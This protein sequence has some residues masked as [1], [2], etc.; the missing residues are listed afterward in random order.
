MRANVEERF[1][2][3]D[4]LQNPDAGFSDQAEELKAQALE[5][6]LTAQARFTEG[7]ELVKS[8]VTKQPA[9]ALGIALGV[10]VVLGWLIK[11]R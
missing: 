2:M 11:R 8:Y 7:S 5:Y 6:A 9:R 1:P 4:R 10:G 3:I